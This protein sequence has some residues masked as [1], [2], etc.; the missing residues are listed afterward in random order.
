MFNGD[1]MYTGPDLSPDALV[2]QWN[3]GYRGEE[4]QQYH[5]HHHLHRGV[6]YE[7]HVAP[8]QPTCRW[9]LP[10]PTQRILDLT[11]TN[12]LLTTRATST[13]AATCN[14]FAQPPRST[15]LEHI[16]TARAPQ[17]PTNTDITIQSPKAIDRGRQSCG[18]SICRTAPWRLG[19][20][21]LSRPEHGAPLH[22]GHHPGRWTFEP[23]S[24]RSDLLLRCQ[25]FLPGH[26]QVLQDRIRG[27]LR[28][29]ID[30]AAAAAA[31]RWSSAPYITHFGDPRWSSVLGAAFPFGDG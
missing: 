11:K 8:S 4:V 24:K 5:H 29:G 23:S 12:S 15:R 1:S 25:P 30:L 31:I 17:P 18:S 14:R 2:M 9:K 27:I 6:A 3:N 28:N 19:C 13:P 7:H 10:F 22:A 26:D 20:R 21:N 16:T